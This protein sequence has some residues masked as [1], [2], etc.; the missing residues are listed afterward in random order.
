MK[1]SDLGRV[2]VAAILLSF[3]NSQAAV[4]AAPNARA[5]WVDG[6][7]V[8]LTWD[9]VPTANFY[10]VYRYDSTSAD[11]IVAD[12]DF[13]A[14]M[15][16]ETPPHEPPLQYAVVALNAEGQSTASLVT[17]EESG[18]ATTMISV[19][20]PDYYFGTLTETNAY[21][22]FW[23]SIISGTD[24]L[25]EIGESVDALAFYAYQPEYAGG[26][27]FNVTNLTPGT[28]YFYRLTVTEQSRFG[29]TYLNSFVTVPANVAPVVSDVTVGWPGW[30]Q[31]DINLSA[32][33][34]ENWQPL[35]ATMLTTPTKGN[36]I[37]IYE[38]GYGSWVAIYEPAEMARGTDSFQIV[39]SDGVSESAVATVTITN[40]YMN[41]WPVAA[42]LQVQTLEDTPVEI[43]LQGTDADLDPL[44]FEVAY[45]SD[46]TLSG[47]PPNLVW[48][49]PANFSGTSWINFI[50]SDGVGFAYGLVEVTVTAVNDSPTAEDIAVAGP[51]DTELPIALTGSDVEWDALTF[52]MLTEPEH[53]TLS[54]EP[55]NLVYTPAANFNG[56]DV[57]TY[58]VNDFAG[59]SQAAVVMIEIAA[60]NDQPTAQNLP[61]VTSYN[62]PVNITLQGADVEGS[63][64]QFAVQTNPANG[65]LSGTAPNLVF[66][67]T[68]GWSGTTSFTYT[69]SD[70]QIQSPAAV[71]TIT[72][73]APAATPIAPSALVATP[74][75]RS[76]INLA[77]SDNSSNEDGFKIERY[78]NGWVQIGTVGP[79]ATSFSSTGLS[80]NKTY[81]HRVRAYNTLG[82]SAY[83]NTASART[84]K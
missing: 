43:E 36:V 60:V 37:A 26:H 84:L 48:T 58:R 22:S 52:E 32:S 83:S 30:T 57:F 67:P 81:Q 77:W 6:F 21:L 66:T 72:V 73:Q 40:L 27:G 25:L 59:S 29:F 12:M 64:L 61:I 47:T 80:A 51:E 17:I 74:V 19:M 35:T 13:T 24:G 71:V 1:F 49:P 46:G 82:N 3:C 20:H 65:V 44:T 4:P 23:S 5:A 70:G 10:G 63:P 39:V 50:V 18:A 14:P 76:Q 11:W 62:T 31:M 8:V 9:A 53:G 41:R 69:V 68:I 2:I 34:P 54:G 79:N 16:R 38:T 33:N 45:L 28:Q 15:F 78:N 7:S 75:S 42:D 56:I 55:P